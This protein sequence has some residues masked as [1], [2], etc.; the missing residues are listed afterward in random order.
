MLLTTSQDREFQKI[1]NHRG[2]TTGDAFG[3]LAHLGA[4]RAYAVSGETAK[5]R[6]AYQD[7][8]NFCKD[9]DPD[10]PSTSRPKR[11]AEVAITARHIV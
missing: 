4:A 6:A 3:G 5:A 8:L 7:F 1:V 11:N 9:G 10:I 2:I